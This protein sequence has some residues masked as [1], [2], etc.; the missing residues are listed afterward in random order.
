M[1]IAGVI[2]LELFLES[3]VEIKNKN[4]WNKWKNK[5]NY[6]PKRPISRMHSWSSEFTRKIQTRNLFLEKL[7]T[8]ICDSKSKWRS[9]N[10]RIFE[11]GTWKRTYPPINYKWSYTCGSRSHVIKRSAART[12]ARRSLKWRLRSGDSRVNRH[13]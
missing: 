1:L 10:N 13:Q 3:L 12:M 9:R 2:K 11:K 5:E 7:Q 6:L 4:K 8:P